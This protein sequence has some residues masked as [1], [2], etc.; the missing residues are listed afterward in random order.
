MPG[1]AIPE[2]KVLAT[3]TGDQIARACSSAPP[4]VTQ[5]SR[6]ALTPVKPCLSC[7][8]GS[9]CLPLSLPRTYT[10]LRLPVWP[11]GFALG[12]MPDSDCTCDCVLPHPLVSAPSKS[13]THACPSGHSEP[14]LFPGSSTN[15]PRTRSARSSNCSKGRLRAAGLRSDEA[16]S[17]PVLR[18]DLI[19]QSESI[20][21]PDSPPV[22]I[23]NLDPRCRILL[24][25]ARSTCMSKAAASCPVSPP[26]PA[27]PNRRSARSLIQYS[28]AS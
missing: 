6:V 2:Y 1:A 12:P 9:S 3:G 27:A 5:S 7:A 28:L 20:S 11:E 21:R 26:R 4:P 24:R 23:P 16:Q 22:L 17:D 18:P 19:G 13:S 8:L 15:I 14:R 10:R 25:P